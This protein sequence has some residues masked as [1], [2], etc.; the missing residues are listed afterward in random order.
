MELVIFD[1][2]RNR[3]IEFFNSWNIHLRFDAI[4]SPF[5]LDYF[6][7]PNAQNFQEIKDLSCVGHYHICYLYHDGELLLTGYILSIKFHEQAIPTLVTISGYALPGFLEDC[8]IPT[9]EA[10]DN[11][12][13]AGNLK[14]AGGT[15]KPYCYPI[16][17]DSL[18]LRQIATKYLAPFKLGF[19][20]DSSVSSL[21]DEVFDHT[22]AK[23]KDSVKSLLTELCAQKNINI[24]HDER[25]N[26]VFTKVKTNLKPLLNFDNPKGNSIPGTQMDLIFDGQRM[27]SQITVMKQ[28]DVE[29]DNS[30]QATVHNPFVPHVFRPKTIIQS[31]GSDV[32]TALAAKNALAEE[33]KSIRLNISLSTWKNSEN[34]IIK[35]NNVLTVIN[36]R[37]YM[38][39]KTKWFIEA[40]TLKG[41][42]KALTST[43]ECVPPFV[44]DGTDPVYFF[45]GIN[46][47]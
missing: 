14:I 18:T 47:H 1:R 28:A 32:D 2:I 22:E 25:G 19:T 15:P 13:S 20:V 27:H 9:D 12:L 21:M 24:S 4:A 38:F 42:Q 29:A 10:I 5:S 23:P 30:G 44:Y 40:V 45:K 36:P 43:I 37:V 11:A 34:K 3:K 46:L 17:D 35:P 33:L 8:S 41:D 6:Y 16:Q 39:N 7:D 26:I 31:S